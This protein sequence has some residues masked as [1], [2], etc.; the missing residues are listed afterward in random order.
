MINLKSHKNAILYYTSFSMND[1]DLMQAHI[2]TSGEKFHYLVSY[3]DVKD[4]FED[5]S[6]Q[7][8]LDIAWTAATSL[9][10]NSSAPIRFRYDYLL[11]LVLTIFIIFCVIKVVVFL[12][13]N[14]NNIDNHI[15]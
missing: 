10:L 13:N 6:R 15:T 12:S 5:P 2:L 11:W 1:T 3:T 4:N 8:H 9:V 7:Y 14:K